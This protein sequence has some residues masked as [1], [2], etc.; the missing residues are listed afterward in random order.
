[1]TL[2]LSQGTEIRMGRGHP[3]FLIAGPC[4]VESRSKTLTIARIL[5]E[6][7]G[8]FGVPLIFKASYDKANRSSQGTFRGL[9]MTEGL[10]V[11]AE[12][13][14]TYGLPLLSDVHES[15]QVERAAETLDVLQVPAFLCRQTDLLHACGKTGRVVNVKKGQ[16]LA[17]EDMAN[18]AAKVEAAGGT[19]ILLTERGASFGYHTLVTDLRALPIMARTGWPVVFDGTHSVQRPGALGNTSGGDREMIPYLVRGAVACGVDGLFLECHDDP[20]HA[21]SDGPNNLDL[22]D[23]PKL[24]REILAIRHALGQT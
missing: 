2:Q 19:R 14:A 9:G 22:K 10:E 1:M 18:V 21:L 4:V 3:L 24:L 23:L 5:R 6:I 15:V 16:F 12:V 17:P 11:L 8:E 13:K 7:C 20:D